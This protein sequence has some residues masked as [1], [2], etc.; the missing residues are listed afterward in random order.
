MFNFKKERTPD[1]VVMC[2]KI[3]RT[4]LEIGVSGQR[5]IPSRPQMAQ[6]H[7]S[8]VACKAFSRPS[9]EVMA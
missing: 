1:L 8:L 7:A 3:P 5:P 2:T 6:E 9:N 4:P